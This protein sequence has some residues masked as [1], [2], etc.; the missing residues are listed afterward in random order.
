VLEHLGI[1]LGPSDSG[2]QRAGILV[3]T[4]GWL[5]NLKRR[6]KSSLTRLHRTSIDDLLAL[7]AFVA[8]HASMAAI[9]MHALLLV[10]GISLPLCGV[11]AALSRSRLRSSPEWRAV[12]AAVLSLL[13]YQ[14]LFWLGHITGA[15]VPFGA[16]VGG[17]ELLVLSVWL[18]VLPMVCVVAIG[19]ALGQIRV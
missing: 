3:M 16:S 5:R 9:S 2:S 17:P 13:Y 1:P 6:I 18:S 19:W 10:F 15:Y 14:A 12:L 4:E 8:F 7:T 11:L